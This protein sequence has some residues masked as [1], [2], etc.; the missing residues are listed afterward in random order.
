VHAPSWSNAE[1][2]STGEVPKIVGN[3]EVRAGL[4][5]ELENK[6][7]CR[8]LEHGPPQKEDLAPVADAAYVVKDVVDVAMGKA[9]FAG[10]PLGHVLVTSTLPG[11]RN[12]A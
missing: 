7:V 4:D 9:K 11:K 3:D 12:P 5:R 2:L 10:N 8:F 6:V 1:L